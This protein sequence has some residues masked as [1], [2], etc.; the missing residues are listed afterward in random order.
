MK[1]WKIFIIGG[2]ALI[3]S[4]L[5]IA[6]FVVSAYLT[7]AFAGYWPLIPGIL[8][9][10]LPPMWVLE[11]RPMIPVFGP[12]YEMNYFTDY[13]EVTGAGLVFFG[14]IGLVMI[15]GGLWLKKEEEKMRRKRS[16]ALF[17]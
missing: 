13:V 17:V 9:P 10:K 7:G 6:R 5:T 14:L 12:F 15:V 4:Y 8:P 3:L 2:A 11:T 16:G 1:D